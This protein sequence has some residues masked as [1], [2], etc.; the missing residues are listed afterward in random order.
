MGGK[1]FFWGFF[2]FTI[3]PID[4]EKK[5]NRTDTRREEGAA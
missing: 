5:T 1:G 3:D 2:I 4:R